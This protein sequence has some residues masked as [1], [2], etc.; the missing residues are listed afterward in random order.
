M[1]AN[2]ILDSAEWFASICAFCKVGLSGRPALGKSISSCDL[3][4]DKSP[5]LTPW[6]RKCGITRGKIIYPVSA[7]YTD[8]SPA[9]ALSINRQEKHCRHCGR[10]ASR[11]M[12]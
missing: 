4:E 7:P 11:C 6:T 3:N 12:F 8:E 2:R 9:H 5:H 1:I 10:A